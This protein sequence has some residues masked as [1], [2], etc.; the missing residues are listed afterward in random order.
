M[1]P[2]MLDR[3][4]NFSAMVEKEEDK[5]SEEPERSSWGNQ[6]DFFMSCVGYAVG[7]GNIWRFPYLCYKNGGGESALLRLSLGIVALLPW[8]LR[9]L[10][11]GTE[12]LLGLAFTW[13]E[14]CGCLWHKPAEIA[15]SFR[16]L[17]VT[18]S[19]FVALSTAFHSTDSPHNS[20]LSH[21]VLPVLFLPYWSFQLYT[22]LWKFH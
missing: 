3:T 15:H 19:V 7:L 18:I 6:L 12:P 21:S 9:V 2:S 13:W 20:P 14:W 22:Y 8:V 1:F 5:R 10:W 11:Y 4:R 17:L 16:S